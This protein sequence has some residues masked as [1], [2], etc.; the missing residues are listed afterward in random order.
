T[1]DAQERQKLTERAIAQLQDSLATGAQPEYAHFNLGWLL[2]DVDPA[3]AA[4]HFKA[5]AQLAPTRGGVYLGLALCELAQD[6]HYAA[7]RS[8]ALE[9]LNDPAFSTAPLWELPDFERLRTD[10]L[11][12]LDTLSR[13]PGGQ[14]DAI[15]NRIAWIRWWTSAQP[16]LPVPSGYSRASEAFSNATQAIEANQPI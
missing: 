3:R 14:L 16:S 7:I 8:L 9:I 10:V 12:E 5:A 1:A 15:K 11:Q 2:L 13:Q 4:A 6:R